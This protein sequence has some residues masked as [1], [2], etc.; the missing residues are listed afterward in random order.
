[1]SASEEHARLSPEEAYAAMY[2]F[3]DAY[4]ERGGRSAEELAI[5][6][7]GMAIL[8]DGSPADPALWAEW[9]DAI[10]AVRAREAP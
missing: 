6:L 1:M 10:R 7:G 3:L 5:L 9:I 4:W 8:P 2:A